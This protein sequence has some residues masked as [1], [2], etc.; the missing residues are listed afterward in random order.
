MRTEKSLK[1]PL[2]LVSV[3]LIM[4][5]PS[6]KL[7]KG[8]EDY[9]QEEALEIQ[10]YI[11]DNDTIDFELKPSGLYYSELETGTG[12]QAD[13]YDTLSLVYTAKFVSGLT[14]DTCVGI[15]TI[16]YILNEYYSIAGFTEG[17]L[18]MKEGGR[19][20]FLIPSG[21][22]FGPYVT[23][24]QG[25]QGSVSIRGFTPLVFIVDLLKVDQYSEKK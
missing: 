16:K 25:Y 13:L 14:F 1:N 2:V 24:Y 20:V 22:A 11:S 12:P 19:S 23:E 18:Y 6:C 15:D 17:L 3:I 7:D 21:L 10:K 9:A 5:I 8:Q 4:L